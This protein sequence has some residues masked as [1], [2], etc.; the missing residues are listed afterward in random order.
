MPVIIVAHK[1]SSFALN[2]LQF[3]D[4]F[5]LMRVTDA[6]G[7]LEV[8]SY[9][10]K[11][12]GTLHWSG[13]SPEVPSQHTKDLVSLFG[14]MV[15]LKVLFKF[16]WQ[17]YPQPRYCWWSTVSKV[18]PWMMKLVVKAQFLSFGA[19][20]HDITFFGIE[21]HLPFSTPFVKLVN[22]VL[23]FHT[24]GSIVDNFI[25]NAVICKKS[26]LIYSDS[27]PRVT[28]PHEIQ[29]FCPSIPLMNS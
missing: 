13:I 2:H 16:V 3:V 22:I 18:C 12:S 5:G 17:E 14:N 11:I 1:S 4:I 21:L 28:D 20:I 26:F 15:V 25:Q 6:G 9:K 10:C 24:I 8:G 23:K 19:H 7:I 27:W 29:A